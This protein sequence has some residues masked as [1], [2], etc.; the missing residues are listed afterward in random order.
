MTL[1]ALQDIENL[2]PRGPPLSRRD[3][4][5]HQEGILSPVEEGKVPGQIVQ[6]LLREPEGRHV[7]LEPRPDLPGAGS[8][9]ERKEPAALHFC[10][11]PL[12]DRGRE[13][14]IGDKRPKGAT[15]SFDDVAAL[16]VVVLHDAP[17][18]LERS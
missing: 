6:L 4:V 17:A 9:Q 11:L 18:A 15:E 13:R 14:W 10:S 7:D 3:V 5:L 2:A 8:L 16:A 1:L 12:D